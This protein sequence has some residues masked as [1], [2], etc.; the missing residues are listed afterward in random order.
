MSEQTGGV[1]I[2]AANAPSPLWGLVFE[3]IRFRRERAVVIALDARQRRDVGVTLDELQARY[4]SF[5]RW[6]QTSAR[7]RRKTASPPPGS[8][9]IV[10]VHRDATACAR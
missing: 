6:R 4:G 7:S 9:A 1:E 3:Y 2:S 8:G 5:W 10:E